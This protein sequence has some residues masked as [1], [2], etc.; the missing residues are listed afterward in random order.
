MHSQRSSIP[1]EQASQTLISGQQDAWKIQPHFL[2][3]SITFLLFLSFSLA[4]T[5]GV[6]IYSLDDP[7]IHLA[8]AENITQGHYGINTSEMAA[9]SSSILWPFLLAFFSAF[10]LIPL[11]LNMGLT[12]INLSI[13]T[14]LLRSTQPA[15]LVSNNK[16]N[17]TA[18]ILLV[19][20][21][22]I[23]LP[24]TGMEHVLHTTLTLVI[25][26]GMHQL[27]DGKKVASWLW[28]A[29]ILNPLV[30][31]EGLAMSG[32]ALLYIMYFGGTIRAMFAGLTI[33]SIMGAFSGFLYS[34]DLGMLP[35]SVI[36]KSQASSTFQEVH[37]HFDVLIGNLTHAGG[38]LCLFLVILNTLAL[39]KQKITRSSL[40]HWCI[41]AA[42]F[43]HFIVGR[44]G[45]YGR[46]EIYI[47][48][49]LAVSFIQ[50]NREWF[51]SLLESPLNKQKMGFL[52]LFILLTAQYALTTL[53]TPHASK[54][55]YSQ[56]YQMH[57]FLTEFWN[58]PAAINDLGWAAY[59]NDQYILDIWG[60]GS[61]EALRLQ[62]TNPESWLA[63]LVEGKNV[64]LAI[65]Y[66]QAFAES[67]PASWQ[68]LATLTI[69]GISITP[70]YREVN[71]F[72]IN[73]N[74]RDSVLAALNEFG[75]TIPEGVELVL[76]NTHT[77]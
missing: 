52:I 8:L 41:V 20:F 2:A 34:N 16:L 72:L 56:Q 64:D 22:G 18:F 65:I 7:Y 11:L 43:T 29:I 1:I 9:P 58:Q 12:F 44:F 70:A 21:N 77:N 19:S 42:A 55:I 26:F 76:T 57:R 73:A 15:L 10:E 59:H 48:L 75:E 14:E 32:L 23:G 66:K 4:L 28:L 68:E 50:L 47:C 13:I 37:S 17:T 49:P 54:S 27:S 61:M 24:F 60:L 40:V 51:Q 31:Y 5:N 69:T 67:I 33:V 6:F 38:I 71:F 25:I 63:N 53:T 36:A 46:Y 39:R 62:Q 45:W 30:R 74:Q 3:L 35:S